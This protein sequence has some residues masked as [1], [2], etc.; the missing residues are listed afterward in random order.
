MAHLMS[1]NPFQ[2]GAGLLPGYMGH[3]EGIERPLLDIVNRLRAGQRGP[4]LAYLYGPR[5][6]GKTV[7]LQWLAEQARPKAG[8]TAIAQVRLLPEHLT[9][10]EALIQR[11]H[12]AVSQTPGMFD[13]LTVNLEAG[14]PGVSF[15]V[16]SETPGDPILGLS[17]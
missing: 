5:G 16:G 13:N 12:S 10:S 6:N 8:E 14:I 15:K 2:P 11:I 4:R 1:M 9:T 17:D 7:L 3:R